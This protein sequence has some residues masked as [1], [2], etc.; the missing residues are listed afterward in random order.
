MAGSA[1]VLTGPAT[2]LQ[3]EHVRRA[4]REATRTALA[5]YHRHCNECRLW[6]MQNTR[7]VI[8]KD[9]LQ[10]QN[11]VEDAREAS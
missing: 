8:Q 3:G 1:A 5:R 2:L 4:R 9:V 10:M 7:V 6:Q 11:A